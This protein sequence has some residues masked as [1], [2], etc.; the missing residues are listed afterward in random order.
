MTIVLAFYRAL[1]VADG[2]GASALVIPEKRVKGPFNEQS[3]HDFFGA[4]SA[5]LKVIDPS[6]IDDDT[7]PVQYTYRTNAGKSCDDRA[8]VHTTGQ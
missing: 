2:E 8:E 3:I 4:M 6:L 5:P 7:L 1:S